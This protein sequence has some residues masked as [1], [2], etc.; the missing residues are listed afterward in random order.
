MESTQESLVL[1]HLIIA[2]YLQLTG[3]VVGSTIRSSIG[4][5]VTSVMELSVQMSEV[6]LQYVLVHIVN[7][8]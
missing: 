7:L 6:L 8:D 3:V 4:I 1:I 2:S 5:S